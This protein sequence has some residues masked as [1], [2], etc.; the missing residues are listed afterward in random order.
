MKYYLNVN[1]NFLD[2]LYSYYDWLEND[3]VIN[4]VKIPVYKI[5]NKKFIDICSNNIKIDKVFLEDIKNKTIISSGI[6]KYALILTNGNN[7]IAIIFNDKG[8]SFLYSVMN[9]KDELN[10]NK[11]SYKLKPV[12]IKYIV[13]S[14]KDKISSRYN[15]IYIEN[16]LN[17]LNIMY[18]NKNYSFINYIYMHLYSKNDTSIHKKYKKLISEDSIL[19]DIYPLLKELNLV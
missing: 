15:K 5:S 12:N 8:H 3:F 19:L 7:S 16:I 14:K 1:L 6:I 4:I 10:I 18:I 11:L 13:I 9:Y 17:I 2:N